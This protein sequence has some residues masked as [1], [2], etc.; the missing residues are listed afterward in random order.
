MKHSLEAMEKTEFNAFSKKPKAPPIERTIISSLWSEAPNTEPLHVR[1]EQLLD[2]IFTMLSAGECGSVL[3]GS[4]QE[5][6]L[7]KALEA[8][9][10]ELYGAALWPTTA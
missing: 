9:C 3:L 4:Y 2:F 8:E 1:L 10:V 5:R 7:L 6:V